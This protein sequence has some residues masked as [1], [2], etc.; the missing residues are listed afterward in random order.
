MPDLSFSTAPILSVVSPMHCEGA[1]VSAFVA[2]VEEVLAPLGLSY[3]IILVDDGSTDDTWQ[4]MTQE[5]ACRPSLRC[6]RLSRNFGKEAAMVAGLEAAR[7]QAIISLDGDLQH[8]PDLIPEMVRIW[9]RGEAD[10]VEARKEQR[11]KESALSRF[12]AGAFYSLFAWVTSLDLRDAGDFKLLDRKVLDAWKKLP[13]RRVFFRGMSGWVGFRRA[14]VL[15]TP[16]ER[17]TGTSQWSFLSKLVLALDSLS[18]YTAKPLSLIWVLGLIFVIFAVFVG[19]EA[20]WAKFTGEALTGFTTVILVLLITGA[21][22]LGSICLLSLYIRQIFH[23]VKQ[24][25]R[26]LIGERTDEVTI[27]RPVS[28]KCPSPAHS[29]ADGRAHLTDRSVRSTPR[30]LVRRKPGV[31]RAVK[32]GGIRARI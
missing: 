16:A 14:E 9:Q 11:Q 17:L 2:K 10:L 12:L 31:A 4:R 25:P 8:P 1:G 13:E 30:R 15:F 26:Y 28:P 19:G 5:A 6:L 29:E 3:E 24:R 27:P 18:A 7:G 23:E 20:L 32:A 22:I 21:A